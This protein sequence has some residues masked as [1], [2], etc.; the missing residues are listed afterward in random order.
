MLRSIISSKINIFSNH[1]Q[2]QD[3]YDVLVQTG[4]NK[5]S[6]ESAM[7]QC[8]PVGGDLVSLLDWLC[9]NTKDGE[10]LL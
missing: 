7:F 10:L 5:E 1:F 3:M 4:F 8:L 6:I 9:L 2:L